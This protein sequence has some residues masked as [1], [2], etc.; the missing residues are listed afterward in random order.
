MMDTRSN[1]MRNIPMRVE[2]PYVS[3]IFQPGASFSDFSE[4]E[5]SIQGGSMSMSPQY[6]ITQSY[7]F[8][9]SDPA[10]SEY[11]QTEKH[12]KQTN[13]VKSLQRQSF[14]T[15]TRW[16]DHNNHTLEQNEMD[17]T[18]SGWGGSMNP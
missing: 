6:R 11:K 3:N 10:P 9:Q 16:M 17:P 12:A 8:L 14:V 5:S 1:R 7:C 4:S 15:E 2:W 18:S 13:L